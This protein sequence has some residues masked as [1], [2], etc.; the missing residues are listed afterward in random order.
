MDTSPPRAAFRAAQTVDTMQNRV[1]HRTI[2]REQHFNFPQIPHVAA[3]L[4]F[5]SGK[6]LAIDGFLFRRADIQVPDDTYRSA[7]RLLQYMC[8]FVPE[9]LPPGGRLRLIALAVEDDILTRCIGRCADRARGRRRTCVGMDVHLL[10]R[11]AE[12]RLEECACIGVERSPG[13]GQAFVPYKRDRD[14]NRFAC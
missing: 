10:E 6:L 1:R 7:L 2:D 8:Q 5:L 14:E 9:Q 3:P 12:L 11:T 13:R 4:V